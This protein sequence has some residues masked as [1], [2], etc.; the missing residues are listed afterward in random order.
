M[1]RKKTADTHMAP[2]STSVT[3]IEGVVIW[4]SA[5]EFCVAD[6]HLGP[7]I[8]VV[9]GDKIDPAG[10]KDAVTVRLAEPP[11]VLG[12]LPGK[13]TRQVVTDGRPGAARLSR[14]RRKAR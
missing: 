13:V 12:N 1:T 4:V 10:L 14:K 11:E 3:G 2:R 5:G 8:L 7:R 9:H 6:R